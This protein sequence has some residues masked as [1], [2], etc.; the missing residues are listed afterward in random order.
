MAAEKDLRNEQEKRESEAAEKRRKAREGE[1]GFRW[2]LASTHAV[3][4]DLSFQCMQASRSA[5]LSWLRRQAC[6]L[7]TGCQCIDAGVLLTS[8]Q[9]ID[10]TSSHMLLA[11]PLCCVQ[12]TCSCAPA[13]QAGLCDQPRQQG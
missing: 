10:K 12:D 9:S 6:V 3:G 2:G 4:C 11:C 8:C 13:R 7:L 1:D 5:I